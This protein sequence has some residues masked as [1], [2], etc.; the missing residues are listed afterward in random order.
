MIASGAK[1]TRHGDTEW[2][3]MSISELIK[4]KDVLEA[5]LGTTASTRV[6]QVRFMT[7]KGLD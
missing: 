4:A 2:E 5:Q 1:R 3:G 7:S 6:K